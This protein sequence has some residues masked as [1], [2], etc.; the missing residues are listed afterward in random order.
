MLLSALSLG[1]YA[2]WL[3]VLHPPGQPTV[4][5]NPTPKPKGSASAAPVV[6]SGPRAV[7]TDA[8]ATKI[9]HAQELLA[10]GDGKGALDAF[11]DAMKGGASVARSVY[12]HMSVAIE[13]PSGPCK[14][15]GVSRPRPYSIELP[16]SRPTLLHS[17]AGTVFVW[18]DNHQDPK[19]RQ[20]Y[21][22]LL[23]DALRRTSPDIPVTPEAYSA[24]QVQLIPAGD[25]FVLLYW[26]D[27]GN[28]PGVYARFISHDG[29]IAGPPRLISSVKKGDLFAAITPGEGGKFWA[30]WQEEVDKGSSD[31]V[32][33]ELDADLQPLGDPV[34]LTAILAPKASTTAAGTPAIAVAHGHLYVSFSINRGFEHLQVYLLRVPLSDAS[35]KTGLLPPKKPTNQE[36]FVG[37][38]Q[39]LSRDGKNTTP[40]I[41]CA[42]D[43]C[44][45]AWD[46]DKAG[47]SVAFVDKDKG[48][49][50]WR[51]DMPLKV[52]RPAVAVAGNSAVISW[53]DESRLRIAPLT[54]DGIGA[55]TSLSR[56]SGF[57]PQPDLA[58]GEKPGQWYIS[59]RDYESAHLEVFALRTECP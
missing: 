21:A 26:D 37:Q 45:V 48:Q 4:V 6:T 39:L 20:A 58:A 57:Q 14:L 49:M 9:A 50:L 13:E 53:F 35:L 46:D 51:R 55:V 19:K 16:V 11:K 23:D 18:V 44:F 38:A 27:G 59:W 33:R 24:R 1:A 36:R 5:H 34:R 47:A 25:K 40:V 28:E 29:H 41:A 54:R 52:V 12:S 43:G 10:G 15:T 3:Y 31:I 22:V 8:Y 7:E 56:V 30:A 42:T 17:S 2:I 32:A